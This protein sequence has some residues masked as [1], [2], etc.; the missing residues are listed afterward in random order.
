MLNRTIDKFIG[1]A[2][3]AINAHEESINEFN[4]VIRDLRLK[5]QDVEKPNSSDRASLFTSNFYTTNAQLKLQ[6]VKNKLPFMLRKNQI[7]GYNSHE[8]KISKNFE[9][10]KKLVR[11][12]Q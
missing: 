12:V 8:S 9:Q 10:P 4:S 11:P 6:S 1:D 2:R 5:I 7:P 3:A